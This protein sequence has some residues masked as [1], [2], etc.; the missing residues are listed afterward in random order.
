MSSSRVHSDL[1]RA[2]VL[3]ALQDLGGFRAMYGGRRRAPTETAAGK[4][5][6]D[7]HL[8]GLEAEHGGGNALV[9]GLELRAEIHLDAAVV[10]YDG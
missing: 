4:Q 8:L 7:L 5:R 10:R 6:V 2:L 3:G 1:D 9:D